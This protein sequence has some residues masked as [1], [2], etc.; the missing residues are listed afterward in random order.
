MSQWS[1]VSPYLNWRYSGLGDALRAGV[2]VV[3]DGL[4]IARPEYEPLA[5]GTQ[6]YF[7]PQAAGG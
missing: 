2:S 7:V 5:D 4:R 1:T 6:V 3:I